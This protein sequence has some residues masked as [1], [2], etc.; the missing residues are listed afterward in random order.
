[1][2]ARQSRSRSLESAASTE[3]RDRPDLRERAR[4]F[5]TPL[6]FFREKKEKTRRLSRPT[7]DKKK[8]K[9]KSVFVLRV[10]TKTRRGF[11]WLFEEVRAERR[12]A[13]EPLG[14]RFLGADVRK[15]R[16]EVVL[17]VICDRLG[18]ACG[19]RMASVERYV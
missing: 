1:M 14:G 12:A 5:H 6:S 13:A 16:R 3:G 18:L 9:Y 19:K 15:T 11:C 2:A 17:E 4:V 10:R 7:G 8:K